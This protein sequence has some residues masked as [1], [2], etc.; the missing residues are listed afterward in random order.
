MALLRAVEAFISSFNKVNLERQRQK[1]I[2]LAYMKVFFACGQ[3][4]NW[5]VA[6]QLPPRLNQ[7]EKK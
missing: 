6:F 1:A 4:K 5:I 2:A 7:K 3:L